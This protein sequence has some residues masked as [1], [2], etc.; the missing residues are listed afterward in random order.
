MR[1][2]LCGLNLSSYLSSVLRWVEVR[3]QAG[4]AVSVCVCVCV[5][6][7]VECWGSVVSEF[8]FRSVGLCG[9]QMMFPD[10]VSR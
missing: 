6:V 4:H 9:F 2:R 3:A 8:G 5:C 7:A 1:V 10:D